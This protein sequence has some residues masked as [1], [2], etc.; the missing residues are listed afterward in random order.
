MAKPFVAIV[1]RQNVGKSTLL[2]RLVGKQLSIVSDIPGTT[3][4]RVAASISWHEKEFVVVDTGGLELGSDTGMSQAVN[5]QVETAMEE[6]D[7]VLFLVDLKDGVIPSDFEITDLLR[8]SKKPILLVANKGDND[9]FASNAVDFYQLGVGDPLVISA[10]HGLGIS[11]LLDKIISFFPDAP[12]PDTSEDVPKIAIVGRPNVGKS[13]LLNTLLGEERAIVSDIPGTTR[14]ALDTSLGFM[15][16]NV[17]IIDTAGVRRRGRI[18]RG[19]ERYSVLR[20]YRAIDRADIVLLV[21]DATE[22]LA[23]Q[24]MHIAGYVQQEAKG[25]ILIVNKWDLAMDSTV[26]ACDRNI[27]GKLKFLPYAPIIQTSALLKQGIEKIIPLAL[28][29]HK[30]RHKRIPTGE[31]NSVVQRIL[32][33]HTPP[34]SG[35]RQLSLYYVTQAQTSPPTFVFFVN[36]TRLVHFS[37]KRFLENNL[38]EAFGFDGTPIQ[39][40]FK[41]RGEE[42]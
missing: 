5:R 39:L 36:D 9:K 27:R 10:Y 4:D 32:A 25:I 20:S 12:E 13:M 18:D 35:T 1:G 2:N 7:L 8:N 37:Y 17:I 30:E 34:K 19:I 29:V 41:A 38:R 15:G 42:Q 40:V 31:L 6:A 33:S 22:L 21:L 3:R 23:A 28:Q 14:D 16:Q 11:D 26:A 24:D